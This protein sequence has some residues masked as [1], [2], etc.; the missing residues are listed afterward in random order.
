VIVFLVAVFN[1]PKYKNISSTEFMP[2]AEV[3]G[4]KKLSCE[5]RIG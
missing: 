5:A 3:L 1:A 2:E 4:S